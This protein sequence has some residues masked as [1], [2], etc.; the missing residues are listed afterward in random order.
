MIKRTQRGFSLLEITIVVAIVMVIAAMATPSLLTTVRRYQLDSSARN[1]Q[2]ILMRARYEAI[3]QN[4]RIPT[5]YA[6]AAGVNPPE[7]G[8]DLNNN[9]VLDAGEPFLPLSSSVRMIPAGGGQP[10]LA[11][12]GA[13]Y[14]GAT[15]VANP[16]QIYFG[17]VGTVVTNNVGCNP[18]CWTEAN[19]VYILYLQH[20]I[21]QEWAAVTLTPAGRDRVWFWSSGAWQ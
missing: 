17:Q 5:V 9:G 21:T 3:R 7:F 19:T 18:P 6:A 10:A 13:N 8:L 4:L 15:P 16:Y 20:T 14:S 2:S 1:V 12:M 11:S